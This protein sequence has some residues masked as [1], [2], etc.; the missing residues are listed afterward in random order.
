MLNIK[1]L[2]FTLLISSSF[3]LNAAC[4]HS[5]KTP[6]MNNAIFIATEEGEAIIS[7][8]AIEEIKHQR[9]FTKESIKIAEKNL[10]IFNQLKQEHSERFKRIFTSNN[11]NSKNKLKAFFYTR[12]EF[13]NLSSQFIQLGTKILANFSNENLKDHGT[14]TMPNINVSMG[15]KQIAPFLALENQLRKCTNELKTRNLEMMNLD[16]ANPSTQQKT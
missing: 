13:E 5:T 7:L 6:N 3:T 16:P 2:L 11:E 12:T 8:L 15:Y 9:G 14:P 10:T 4:R 1:H